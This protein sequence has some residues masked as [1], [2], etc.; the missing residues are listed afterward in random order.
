MSGVP[1]AP[2][3]QS[4]L[5]TWSPESVEPARR[6][7]SAEPP[8]QAEIGDVQQ[9]VLGLKTKL[10]EAA[11][12]FGRLQKSLV[13]QQ[14]LEH[15]LRQG[16]AHLEDLR[17]QL[18]Q[19]TAERDRLETEFRD[20]QAAHQREVDRL[21][22]QIHEATRQAVLQRT[23]AEQLGRD[24]LAKEQEQR[25]QTDALSE[26]LQKALAERGRLAAHLDEREVAHKQFAEERTEER[27]TFERLLAEA[28]ANQRDMVQDLDE[29]RQQIQT[30]REA[31]MRA[32][33]LARQIMRAHETVLPENRSKS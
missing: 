9:Q 17:S 15:L 28:T 7:D 26:Q 30:L 4:D 27:F 13:P 21:Q 12:E 32:Q 11:S 3:P 5:E 24:L 14:Q 22:T 29:Q 10:E 6:E 2:A 1:F 18:Q 16:R 25:Q 33:S 20:R 8:A 23:L 31:A 19:I